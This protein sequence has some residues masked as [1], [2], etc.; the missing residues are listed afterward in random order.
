MIGCI[1]KYQW[2]PT[3]F[4]GP[5]NKFIYLFIYLFIYYQILVDEKNLNTRYYSIAFNTYYPS[6]LIKIRA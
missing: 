2:D 4:G 3:E 6:T 1:G 5:N